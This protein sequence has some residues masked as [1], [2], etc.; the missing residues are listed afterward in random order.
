MRK[1]I[2]IAAWTLACL[3]LAVGAA[4]EGEGYDEQAM[5]DAWM[6]AAQTG[7]E[8]AG[9]AQMVGQWTTK[10]THYM[11]GEATE[12]SDGTAEFVSM[13]GGRV[14]Q[15]THKG[16]M[17]GMPYEGLSLDGYDNVTGEYWSTWNDSMSTGHYVMRGKTI[18]DD[19]IE[20][21]GTMEMPDGSESRMRIVNTF[22][23]DSGRMDMYETRPGAD[24]EALSMVIEY[25]RTM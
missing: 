4:A 24:E 18:A 20:Y 23:K 3:G 9:L 11:N 1:R 8:H 6:K 17:M 2:R 14:I 16:L 19:K 5:M 7:E 15:G 12:S 10:T 22:G 21:H 13:L 25:T